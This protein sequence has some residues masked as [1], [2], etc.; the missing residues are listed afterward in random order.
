V[1]VSP[2]LTSRNLHLKAGAQYGFDHA[3]F[4]SLL[5]QVGF[6]IQPP[7]LDSRVTDKVYFY[8]LQK[9]HLAV[10]LSITSKKNIKESKQGDTLD[11]GAADK[12]KKNDGRNNDVSSTKQQSGFCVV[13]PSVG[14]GK[15]RKI[16]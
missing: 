4:E 12:H 7:P 9:K 15:R 5:T 2:D 3:V 13:L 1:V 10:A 11:V 16:E 6:T 8:C 14:S